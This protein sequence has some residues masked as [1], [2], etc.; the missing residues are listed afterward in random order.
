MIEKPD[1]EEFARTVLHTLAALSAE[2][3]ELK[4]L[5]CDAL[6]QIKHL[7]AEQIRSHYNQMVLEETDR[8]YFQYLDAAKIPPAPRDGPSEDPNPTAGPPG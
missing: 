3:K 6:A 2:V 8:L 4:L 1:A 5:L 7:P